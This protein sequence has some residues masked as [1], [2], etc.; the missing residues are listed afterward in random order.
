MCNCPTKTGMLQIRVTPDEKRLL[1]DAAR[2]RG[3]TISDLIRQTSFE[4]AQ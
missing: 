1:A 3:V 2:R 4:A